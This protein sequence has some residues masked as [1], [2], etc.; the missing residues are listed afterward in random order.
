MIRIQ[1]RLPTRIKASALPADFSQS[2]LAEIERT[3]TDKSSYDVGDIVNVKGK[4]IELVADSDQSNV[5]NIQSSAS[6][7]NYVGVRQGITGAT[8]FG[9]V[10]DP[11]IDIAFA[12]APSAENIAL[13][14]AQIPRARFAGTPPRFLY[15]NVQGG[16]YADMVLVRQSA[17]D[18][19]QVYGYA[20]SSTGV[21]FPAPAGDA[22]SVRFYTGSA[23][24][25]ST[26]TPLAIHSGNRWENYHDRVLPPDPPSI[27][28]I[29]VDDP[30]SIS[31][32]G[33]AT[34]PGETRQITFTGEVGGLSAVSTTA[35]LRGAGTPTDRLDVSERLD[36]WSQS[37]DGGT[38][39]NESGAVTTI[40]AVALPVSTARTASN[41]AALNYGISQLTAIK[42][43]NYYV[44][45]RIPSAFVGARRMYRLA[46]D[47]VGVHDIDLANE[48]VTQTGGFH[49]YQFQITTINSGVTLRPQVFNA[50]EIDTG[51]VRNQLPL[52]AG[53]G[54]T[55]ERDN[56]TGQW[57]AIDKPSSSAGVTTIG[58]QAWGIAALA[59]QT[60]TVATAGV[61]QFHEVR[62]FTGT[63]P[64]ADTHTSRQTNGI[65][66]D[67]AG[68]YSLDLQFAINLRTGTANGEWGISLLRTNGQTGAGEVIHQSSIFSA[69]IDT[70]A[71]A[72]EY[73]ETLQFP[74]SQFDQNDY[75]Y[76][77][78]AWTGARGA[79]LTFDISPTPLISQLVVRRYDAVPANIDG[80]VD[81]RINS[82]VVRYASESAL[83]AATKP[84]DQ[85][86]WTPRTG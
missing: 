72:E 78:L 19:T 1:R 46:L 16:G 74:I 21:R 22:S 3:P 31:P 81:G 7:G 14:W 6:S 34:R 83:A 63:S 76:A 28:D 56:N 26:S 13:A 68:F 53:Q 32:T 5:L 77:A 69:H 12:W 17:R 75:I 67:T 65:R 71:T 52:G 80:I 33:P 27:V 25:F 37:L 51:R 73:V 48:L 85:W 61:P 70:F 59:N 9:T 4:L 84:A 49:Y 30:L 20:A 40:A 60:L 39:G 82:K 44:C 66:V 23:N 79:A 35:N 86:S 10:R 18:T 15:A 2:T 45:V 54:Q 57:V 47:G 43:D 41:I 11:D 24:I 42:V 50:L 8:D 55:I 58:R 29:Q 36:A 62:T 38:W 64:N